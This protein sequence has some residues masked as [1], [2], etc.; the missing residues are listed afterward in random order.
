MRSGF[1]VPGAIGPVALAVFGWRQRGGVL[2]A[3]DAEASDYFGVSVAL[4][5]DGAV[6]AVGAYQWDG[7]GG[8]NQGGV[9]IYD[10]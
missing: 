10:W 6:L 4:S 1:L 9:Y 7:A 2:T 3:S 5:A 8:S